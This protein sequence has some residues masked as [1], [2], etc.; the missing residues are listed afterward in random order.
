MEK[1]EDICQNLIDKVKSLI[2]FSASVYLAVYLAVIRFMYVGAFLLCDVT[3]LTI[4]FVFFFVPFFFLLT[5]DVDL[6]KRGCPE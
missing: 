6:R 2:I 3:S 5:D 4:I 1:P